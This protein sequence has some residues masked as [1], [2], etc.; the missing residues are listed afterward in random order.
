MVAG[1]A[2]R[3][4]WLKGPECLCNKALGHREGASKGFW[5]DCP[6]ENKKILS[7]RK[8]RSEGGKKE[9][10][11]KANKSRLPSGKYKRSLHVAS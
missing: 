3:G 9:E 1:K 5:I 4:L 11:V 7:V 2:E 8:Q 6:N 10:M